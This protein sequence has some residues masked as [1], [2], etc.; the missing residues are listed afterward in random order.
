MFENDAPQSAKLTELEIRVEHSGDSL[1][2]IC[3]ALESATSA[4]TQ[5]QC[6][7]NPLNNKMRCEIPAIAASLNIDTNNGNDVCDR[8]AQTGTSNACSD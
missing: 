8:N 5:Y 3:N 4:S 7:V 2:D 6:C 1:N